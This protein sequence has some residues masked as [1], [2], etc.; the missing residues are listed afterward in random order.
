MTS[1]SSSFKTIF[2]LVRLRAIL[3]TNLLPLLP[4]LV[5]VE[6]DQVDPLENTDLVV[7]LR[8]A[9]YILLIVAFIRFFLIFKNEI[10]S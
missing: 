6:V 9:L 4:P 5:A 7:A 3:D 10:F 8:P 2:L 1:W